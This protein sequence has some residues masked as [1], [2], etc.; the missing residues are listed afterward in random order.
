[1][2]RRILF[3]CS[4]FLF[5]SCEKREPEKVRLLEFKMNS[6]FVSVEGHAECYNEI[7]NRKS[8]G[9]EWKVYN[10]GSNTLDIDAY[11]STRIKRVFTFPEFRAKYMLEISAGQL[12]TY[13]ATEGK[14][15]LLAPRE[16]DATGD[17][18]FK[19]KNIANPNDSIMIENG[20]FRIW[21]DKYD[22]EF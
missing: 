18:H 19:M 2:Q 11:D 8:I 10:V 21:L 13:H 6:Q 22:R 12:I 1:M 16:G 7:K 9:Y 20:Y 5:I 17:F 4:L 14:F 15:R 3:I